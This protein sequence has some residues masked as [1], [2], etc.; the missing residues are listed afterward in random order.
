MHRHAFDRLA[1]RRSKLVL[2][3]R[4]THWKG[5]LPGDSPFIQGAPHTRHGDD[6]T[7]KIEDC[8]LKLAQSAAVWRRR[9]PHDAGNAG[10]PRG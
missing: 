7:E 10:N 5:V 3:S 4:G 9:G 8:G 1:E 2:F 6:T